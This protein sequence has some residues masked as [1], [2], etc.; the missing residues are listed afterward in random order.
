MRRPTLLLSLL[1]LLVVPAAAHARTFEVRGGGWGHGV[2]MSQYGAQGFAEHGVGYRGILSHYYRKTRLDRA[3]GK[4]VRVLLQASRREPASFSGATRAGGRRLR[5]S[6][7][8]KVKV[9]GSRLVVRASGGRRIGRFRAPLRVAGGDGGVKLDGTALNGVTGGRY[10]GKLELRP[11]A[12]GG[13]TAVNAVRMDDYVRGVIPAEMPPSWRLDALRAQA[14]AARSYA[15]AT[16]VG[17]SVFDAYPD[18]RSQVYRGMTD[19]QVSTDEAVRSTA[20]EVLRH[21]GEVATTFFFSTSGGHTEDNENVFGGAPL[22]Y[23]R[24]V[25]DPYDGISPLHRWDS[26]FTRTEMT[27]KLGSVVQGRFRGVDRVR[28]GA[29]PRMIVAKVRGSAGSTRVS[30][31]TLRSRLGL[32]DMPRSIKPVR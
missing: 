26:R 1:L 7:T 29:S 17:G 15:L 13:V 2:G 14:V 23:L 31:A 20:G 21:G 12:S 6:G 5:P 8:Y 28:R 18:T 9:S 10:R 30:G 25:N 19:E 27:R 3:R 22:P 16:D 24:G 4:R 11:G 32:P